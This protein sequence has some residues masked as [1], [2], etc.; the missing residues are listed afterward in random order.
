MLGQSVELGESKLFRAIVAVVVKVM[1]LLIRVCCRKS[2][3][4]TLLVCEVYK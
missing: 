4:C 3:V 2:P 1:Y